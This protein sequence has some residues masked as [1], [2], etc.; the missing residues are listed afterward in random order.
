MRRKRV[1]EGLNEDQ[2]S[3][4]TAPAGP[5]VV[6][7]GPGT[8]KTLTITA[9]IAYRVADGQ[10]PAGAVLA[11]THS[12]R[13][14]GQLRDGLRRFGVPGLEL[15]AARTVHA[16][17]RNQL[18]YAHQVLGI[19]PEPVMCQDVVATVRDIGR[20]HGVAPAVAGAVAAEIS[21]A[22]SSL[23]APEG[24]AQ[25]AAGAGRVPPVSTE[26]VGQIYA[27]Y[28][29]ALAAREMMDTTDLLTRAAAAVQ[30]HDQLAALVRAKARFLVVDEFQDTD[31]AQAALLEAWLGPNR[32]ITVV[33]DPRQAIYGFKGADPELMG[34][35]TTA[36]PDAHVVHLRTSYRSSPG[37]VTLA[38]RLQTALPVAGAALKSAAPEGPAPVVRGLDTP[39]AE[40]AWVSTQVLAALRD[41]TSPGQVAVLARE[42]QRVADLANALTDAGVPVRTSAST[43]SGDSDAVTAVRTAMRTYLERGWDMSGASLLR[44]VLADYGFDR[45]LPPPPGSVADPVWRVRKGL[46]DWVEGFPAAELLGARELLAELD[47]AAAA[48]HHT[49][50]DAVFVGTVHASKGLE[51]DA[52]FV[53][54]FDSSWG[55]GGQEGNV[56]YVAATR[57]RR[58]LTFT[59]ARTRGGRKVAVSGLARACRFV[60]ADDRTM[61]PEPDSPAKVAKPAR[62]EGVCSRCRA[63]LPR[64]AVAAGVCEQHLSGAALAR[65]SALRAWVREQSTLTGRP[66]AQILSRSA[67]LALAAAGPGDLDTLAQVPGVGPVTLNRYGQELLDVLAGRWVP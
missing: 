37:L 41:G 23:V 45:Q 34:R 51:F 49:P 11:V 12:T 57:A 65:W 52:V 14:A 13:A 31:P 40:A 17:A 36:Y 20:R 59:W 8:G 44:Q 2:L 21:W 56:A 28:Q 48:G 62:G 7:A 53:T 54:G 60:D 27:R 6:N 61:V 50:T 16:A 15:V 63:P 10:L 43:R 35:F 67:A 42:N 38:N 46:L 64:A 30:E 58:W 18:L 19:G 26:V 66:A 3:A 47:Q 55:A 4:V 39:E 22:K 9:R 33:G 5:V 25:A 1:L 24:Y 32:D 29:E